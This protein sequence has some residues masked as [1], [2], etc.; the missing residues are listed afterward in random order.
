MRCGLAL[1][2]S[3]NPPEDSDSQEGRAVLC[4]CIRLLYFYLPIILN[5]QAMR[6]AAGS[7]ALP[8]VSSLW[9]KCLWQSAGRTPAQS[10]SQSFAKAKKKNER[11]V[12]GPNM[13]SFNLD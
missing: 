7:T 9:L 5:Y 11:Q 2:L 3:H 13:T 4:G 1:P 10:L 6:K 12:P 8:T